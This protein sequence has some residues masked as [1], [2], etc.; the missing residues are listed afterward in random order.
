MLF[1]TPIKF[2]C[3]EDRIF[4]QFLQ[5]ATEYVVFLTASPAYA[6][7]LGYGESYIS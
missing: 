4:Y 3:A 7:N 2:S 6:I 5:P 1:F